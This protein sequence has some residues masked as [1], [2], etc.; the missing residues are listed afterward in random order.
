MSL[1]SIILNKLNNIE[2]EGGNVIH[3]IKSSDKN[4]H[5]FGEA[6]FSIVK[7]KFIKGWKKHTK[8][9]MN[10][11]VVKGKVKFVFCL[12]DRMKFREE[13]IDSN[14]FSNILVPPNIW[15]AF[16]GIS[17]I[18]S[19]ILNISNIEHDPSEVKRLEL[20]DIKYNWD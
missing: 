11:S 8:M 5:E 1:N 13:T 3:L 18:P 14:D 4:F 7:P 15:F 19:V 2:V 9:F 16:K 6:Y 20:S 17:K 10:L 12:D